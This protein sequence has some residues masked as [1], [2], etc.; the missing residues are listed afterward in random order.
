MTALFLP[1]IA[2]AVEGKAAG[3]DVRFTWPGKDPSGPGGVT[4]R[5]ARAWLDT[6]RALFPATFGKG[7]RA[8]G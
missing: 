7:R 1:D 3:R 5:L 2:R 4:V 6:Q 8:N